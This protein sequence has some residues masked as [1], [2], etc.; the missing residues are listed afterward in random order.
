MFTW[1]RLGNEVA[2]KPIYWNHNLWPIITEEMD[3]LMLKE[4][5]TLTQVEY[6]SQT[7]IGIIINVC[8][9]V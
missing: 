5:T 7:G 2:N 1:D 3:H 6:T 4:V 8:T 9:L